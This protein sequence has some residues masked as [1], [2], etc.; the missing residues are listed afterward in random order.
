MVQTISRVDLSSLTPDI[1]K[2]QYRKEVK[3]VV[4]T[5]LLDEDSEW[6]LPFLAEKLGDHEFNFR[7]YGKQRNDSQN[8]Q[9]MGVGSGTITRRMRFSDY[10]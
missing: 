5:G 4:I 2:D 1:F 10:E 9:A 7:D 3:P 8:K 6:N